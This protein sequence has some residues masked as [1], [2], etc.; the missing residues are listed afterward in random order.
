MASLESRAAKW[1]L[2]LLA[3]ATH[4]RLGLLSDLVPA[5]AWREFCVLEPWPARL[6]GWVERMPAKHSM[7]QIH[8]SRK[9]VMFTKS[10]RMNLIILQWRSRQVTV[11]FLLPGRLFGRHWIGREV[12]FGF[13]HEPI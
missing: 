10:E 4:L 2:I 12:C 11:L 5:W 6:G 1:C 9:V 3:W 7:T 8:R 13:I